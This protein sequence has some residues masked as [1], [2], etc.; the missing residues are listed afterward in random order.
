MRGSTPTT[1]ATHSTNSR[2]ERV[3]G[4]GTCH[5]SP[6]ARSSPPERDQC[7]PEVLDVRVGVGQV[8]VAEHVG[9]LP[10][11]EVPEDPFPDHGVADTW[12]EEVGPAADRRA[13]DAGLVRVEDA[14]RHL[15]SRP[16]F[17]RLGV[18]R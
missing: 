17:P 7:P 9:S 3:G 1:S 2:V 16:S 6:H 8:G 4:D 10:P 5:T 12:S 18:P 13:D 15:R 14:S 11:K